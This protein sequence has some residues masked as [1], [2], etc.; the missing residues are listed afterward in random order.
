[1]TNRM[2]RPK[3]ERDRP[4]RSF[5]TLFGAPASGRAHSEPDGASETDGSESSNGSSNGADGANGSA[6][7]G[8]AVSET[9]EMGYRVIDDYLRQ[10][11]KVAEAFNPATWMN[12][13]QGGSNEEL[14][15]IAQR[16]MQYGWDFA[17]MWFEMWSR[18]GGAGAWP[19][20]PWM[21][22][23]PFG[24]SPNGQQHGGGPERHASADGM[25]AEPVRLEIDVRS[26]RATS[27][28]IELRPGKTH[29]LILQRLRPAA[30][31]GL[32]IGEASL[33]PAADGHAL[34]LKV[35]VPDEQKAGI[36]NALIVDSRTNLPR[37]TFSITVTDTLTKQTPESAG[38]TDKLGKAP[39][40]K[41]GSARE[42]KR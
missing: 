38:T 7:A 24:P 15:K 14:Q 5:S 11:Q 32:P 21:A 1:M 18:M 8:R 22:G 19:Q 16:V 4:V 34:K 9:V 27:T 29:D 33:E 26:S 35:T 23:M 6:G 39:R 40:R 2:K 13:G 28:S 37:G 42:R 17:G 30:E 10:G 20:G 3:L 25:G 12:P 36:Y 31:D 41:A